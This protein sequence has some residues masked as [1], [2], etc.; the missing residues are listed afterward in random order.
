MITRP[1]PRPSI[2]SSMCSMRSRESS[3]RAEVEEDDQSRP[4]FLVKEL[5]KLLELN[6]LNYLKIQKKY[7]IGKLGNS[8]G[9]PEYSQESQRKKHPRYWK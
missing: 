1:F 8:P 7:F 4:R 2:L 9:K 3:S 6:Q 5:V